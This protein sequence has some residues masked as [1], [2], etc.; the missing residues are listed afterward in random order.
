[1]QS[2]TILS[3]HNKLGQPESFSSLTLNRGELYTIVGNTGSGKSRL[4]KDIEQLTFADSITGRKILLNHEA[5]PMEKRQEYAANLIAHLGQNMRFVLDATTEDFLLLHTQCRQKNISAREVLQLAN[6]ITPE[7]ILEK[8]KLNQL[9][10]G[11]TRALM[12]ADIALICDSPIVLID[13]IENAGIDKEKAFFYLTRQ[14]KL[15]LVVTHDPHTALMAKKRIILEKGGITA[16]RHRTPKEEEVYLQLDR[17]YKLH[18]QYQ[19]LL[20]KGEA[21]L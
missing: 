19:N 21:L 14:D 4:I 11:Q 2:I 20:R 12:I 5:V 9:S 16:I 7:P 18:Q 1:M 6:H 17:T 13:E 10:G 8:Q 3:G 15:V